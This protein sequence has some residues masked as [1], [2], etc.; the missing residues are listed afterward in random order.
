MSR[1]RKRTDDDDED[2]QNGEAQEETKKAPIYVWWTTEVDCRKMGL[3]HVGEVEALPEYL[4]EQYK[5]RFRSTGG[6]RLWIDKKEFKA[7]GDLDAF[8][9]TSRGKYDWI[10]MACK[11]SGGIVVHEC[12][13]P[14]IYRLPGLVTD[15]KLELVYEE[16]RGFCELRDCLW[17]E[18]R[19]D[20]TQQELSRVSCLIP[21]LLNEVMQY[22]VSL[23]WETEM[24][25]WDDDVELLA[26]SSLTTQ[27][28]FA[29]EDM[30][31]RAVA[32]VVQLFGK[33]SPWATER[34][35][36]LERIS[37]HAMKYV[38]DAVK[39]GYIRV[40]F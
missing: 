40:E 3:V 5:S 36:R 31:T 6:G 20:N 39:H 38:F 16:L 21:P 15:Q 9:A 11:E 24:E 7:L 17:L 10:V 37:R 29:L 28:P 2:E 25:I 33:E 4:Q 18:N 8:K 34:R 1:K 32:A 26:M 27:E 22:L 19:L 30:A 23:R 13:V 12:D 14:K 35:S